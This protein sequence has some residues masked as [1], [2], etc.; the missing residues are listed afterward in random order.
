MA[1]RAFN[2]A[3]SGTANSS[4]APRVSNP[5][6]KTTGKFPSVTIP[7]LHQGATGARPVIYN[8][9]GPSG[10]LTVNLPAANKS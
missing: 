2:K 1:W 3:G 5:L 6:W 4:F 7:G 9:Q 10:I 8:G